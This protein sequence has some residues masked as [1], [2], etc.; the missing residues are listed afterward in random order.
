MNQLV[1]EF[2]TKATY[3]GNDFYQKVFY[4]NLKFNFNSNF[5]MYVHN[6][7]RFKITT[8]MLTEAVPNAAQRN[9]PAGTLLSYVTYQDE[10]SPK[11]IVW[12]PTM[13]LSTKE[14][15]IY[16]EDWFFEILKKDE[17]SMHLC[18]RCFADADDDKVLCSACLADTQK[19][20]VCRYCHLEMYNDVVYHLTAQCLLMVTDGSS[21]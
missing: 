15:V 9:V 1:P 4:K 16:N 6:A 20:L 7:N 10:D 18:K 17:I 14:N 11:Q 8:F 2:Y 5:W 12:C 3:K 19:P 13:E 21:R